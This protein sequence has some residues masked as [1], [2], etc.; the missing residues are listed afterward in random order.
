MSRGLGE[1]SRERGKW[2]ARL[3][4][5]LGRKRIGSFE[6][7]AEARRALAVYFGQAAEE[8]ARTLGSWGMEWLRE[9][10]A[11]GRHSEARDDVRRWRRYVV[12]SPI[13]GRPITSVD[14][15][16]MRQWIDGLRRQDGKRIGA[17]T[18]RNAISLLRTAL[19]AACYAGH[20][21]ENPALGIALPAATRAQRSKPGK[22]RMSAVELDRFLWCSSTVPLAPQSILVTMATMGIGPAEAWALE[23][24]HVDLVA[25][26]L[27][28]R[29]L[30]RAARW[31]TL[32]LLPPALAVLKRW[33]H[34][35]TAAGLYS[36]RDLVWPAKDGLQ[37][38]RGYHA[39]IAPVLR[40]AGLQGRG[41]TI[42][43]LRTTAGS[44]LLSGAWVDRGWLTRRLTISEVSRWLG[45]S[46]VT[47]TQRHYARLSDEEVRESVVV[48]RRPQ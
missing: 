13:G 48:R 35:Y 37:H 2:V 43:S 38:A 23:W 26:T 11:E 3:P 30:K 16:D 42:G 41:F 15:G 19:E 8:E 46:N 9:R 4:R 17:Q 25:G 33:R 47:V 34:E 7:Q 12:G 21:R 14:A 22:T 6:T 32:Q 44:L 5:S 24:S 18:A 28:V 36:P 31:R 27:E 40:R 1:A 20:I 45:H 10:A 29:H 39:Q